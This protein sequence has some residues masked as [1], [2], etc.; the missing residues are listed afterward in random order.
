M[1]I[2][3]AVTPEVFL[4]VRQSQ[5][6]ERTVQSSN[7]TAVSVSPTRQSVTAVVNAAETVMMN[8]TVPVSSSVLLHFAFSTFLFPLYDIHS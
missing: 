1:T 7:V 5:N 6:V 3:V 4:I 8:G 2:P